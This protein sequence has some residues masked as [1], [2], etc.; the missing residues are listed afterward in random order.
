M[1][2]VV[3]SPLRHDWLWP[4][5][6]K[7]IHPNICPK[8][9]SYVVLPRF[10]AGSFYVSPVETDFITKLNGELEDF[11]DLKAGCPRLYCMA[12]NCYQA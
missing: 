4:H 12:E 1:Q 11:P 7:P 2:H 3:S 6:W 5:E 8:S 9:S 10:L